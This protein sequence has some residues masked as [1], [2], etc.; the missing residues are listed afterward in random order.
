MAVAEAREPDAEEEAPFEVA[1][2]PLDEP[3]HREM[4]S[5]YEE[6]AHTIR[7]AKSQQW[8]TL[9][10]TLLTFLALIAICYLF[11][12][13]VV[14]AQG[15]AFSTFLVSA[16]AIY[17]LAIY[18]T[19]QNVEREKLRRIAAQ[20]SNLARDI[21]AVKSSLEANFHRYI[22]LTF[23]VFAIIGGNVVVVMAL[24]PLYR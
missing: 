1:P 20:L 15:V 5:L 13:E 17:A 6:S 3:T 7:F 18:Q 9:G 11:S 24:S 19:W 2:S 23:M 4:L 22:L 16:C 14:L 8:K 12:R 21:R 10:S